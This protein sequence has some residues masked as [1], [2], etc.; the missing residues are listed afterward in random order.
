MPAGGDADVVEHGERIAFVPVQ[1]VLD[2][3]NVLPRVREDELAKYLRGEAEAC[4]ARGEFARASALLARLGAIEFASH[5]VASLTFAARVGSGEPVAAARPALDVVLAELPDDASRQ[6]A[7]DRRFKRPPLRRIVS[8][9]SV[10]GDRTPPSR[11]RVGR[12]MTVSAGRRASLARRSGPPARLRASR[13]Q[14]TGSSR[15]SST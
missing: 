4:L 11:T 13:G 1:V 12:G 5:E 6:R 10:R 8:R 15:P 14:A 7:A 9:R 3:E 2:P